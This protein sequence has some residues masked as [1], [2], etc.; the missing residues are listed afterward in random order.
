MV[1]PAQNGVSVLYNLAQTSIYD[2][3]QQAKG[4]TPTVEAFPPSQAPTGYV[5]LIEVE[6]LLQRERGTSLP[7]LPKMDIRPS[8]PLVHARHIL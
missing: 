4:S 5:T 6:S 3:E 1:T 7:F 8:Y 2:A